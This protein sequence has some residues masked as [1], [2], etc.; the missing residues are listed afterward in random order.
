MLPEEERLETLAYL[1]LSEYFRPRSL[2]SLNLTLSSKERTTL[3]DEL[4]RM[5]II[6]ETLAMKARRRRIEAT[7]DELERAVD[8]FSRPVVFVPDPAA[9][10][11]NPES[12]DVFIQSTPRRPP[13]K[14]PAYQGT[15]AFKPGGGQRRPF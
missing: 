13:P 11:E 15:A 3:I 12:N 7:L 4:S 5:P 10:R 8:T 14:T 6:V 1:K 9:E 2:V